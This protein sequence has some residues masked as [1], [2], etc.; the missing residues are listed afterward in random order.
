MRED[1]NILVGVALVT[2]PRGGEAWLGR[3][4]DCR[5]VCEQ[6]GVALCILR[7]GRGLI[8]Y[9]HALSAYLAPAVYST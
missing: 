7:G 3:R 6:R 5:L 8:A 2:L 4:P 1:A 9:P